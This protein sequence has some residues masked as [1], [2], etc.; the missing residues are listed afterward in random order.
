[1]DTKKYRQKRLLLILLSSGI[2]IAAFG[3]ELPLVLPLFGMN[4]VVDEIV[5]YL[6]SKIIA[7]ERIQ[8]KPAYKVAGFI[9]IPGVTSLSL[10]CAIEI[11]RSYQKSPALPNNTP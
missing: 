1:M 6:I 5:E 3:A 9:P 4:F 2:D 8:I 11:F 7:G 10:Q